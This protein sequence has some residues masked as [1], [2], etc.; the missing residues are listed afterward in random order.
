MHLDVGNHG[1]GEHRDFREE[2]RP[3]DVAEIENQL[4][5]EKRLGGLKIQIIEVSPNRDY[6]FAEFFY[7]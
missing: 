2:S 7:P 1:N 6:D 3:W 4:V 5:S